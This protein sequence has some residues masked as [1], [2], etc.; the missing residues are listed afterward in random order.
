MN[1]GNIIIV[2]AMGCGK[3]T[4][5]KLLAKKLDIHKKIDISPLFETKYGLEH[6]QEVIKDLL[7]QKSFIKYVK[8]RKRL[9]IQTGFSDAG[10]F[11][12]QINKIFEQ[13]H[14]KDISYN[15]LLDIDSAIGLLKD[16]ETKKS[17]TQ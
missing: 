16:L 11:I 7:L 8:S 3:S 14:G 10:R 9:S 2:G 17:W 5:G 1:S 15:N 6:G 12:G 4:I 13:I